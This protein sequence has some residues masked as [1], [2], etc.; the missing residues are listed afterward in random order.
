MIC[1]LR[2]WKFG[3]YNKERRETSQDRAKQNYDVARGLD[4]YVCLL[5]LLLV[6]DM[7]HLVY[8]VY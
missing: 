2:E 4:R 5:Y 7:V 8:C 1:E 3:S 6:L